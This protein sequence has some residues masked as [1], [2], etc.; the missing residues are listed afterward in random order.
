MK[1]LL[2][3]VISIVIIAGCTRSDG[4]DVFEE[5]RCIRGVQYYD[6][7]NTLAPVFKQDSTVATCD[8]YS[9]E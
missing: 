3:I 4:T 6:G 5:I 7:Y 8:V 9:F 1:K 2:L